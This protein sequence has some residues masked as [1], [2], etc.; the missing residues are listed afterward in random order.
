[1]DVKIPITKLGVDLSF[2]LADPE[3][4]VPI[5]I[6]STETYSFTLPTPPRSTLK[7]EIHQT[8][9]RMSGQWQVQVTMDFAPVVRS[10]LQRIYQDASWTYLPMKD[11]FGD[12]AAF[13][14]TGDVDV[15]KTVD[16]TFK[17]STV[18]VQQA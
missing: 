4:K 14:V 8:V 12:L 11:N 1:M 5:D 7:I 16:T 17:M 9:G 6:C 10:A 15:A 18:P 2:D 13:T 3:D